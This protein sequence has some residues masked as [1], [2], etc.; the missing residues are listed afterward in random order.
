VGGSLS[1]PQL[2]IV[3]PWFNAP[4]HPAQSLINTA[5]AIGRHDA[6][7]YLVSCETQEDPR[8]AALRAAAGSVATFLLRGS[9]LRRGTWLALRQLLAKKTGGSLAGRVL[10]FD[11]HLALMALLWPFMRGRIRLD[12]LGL[13]YLAGPE[14]IAGNAFLRWRMQY[15][16]AFP[17]VRLFLRTEEL[18]RAWRDRFPECRRE[19]IAVLPSLEIPDSAPPPFLSAAPGEPLRFGVVGQ[20]RKG[21]GLEWLVP[22]FQRRPELGVLAVAGEFSDERAHRQLGFLQTYP[23]YRGGFLTEHALL[24]VARAQ[25]Y[26]LLLYDEWDNRMEAATLYLAARVGRPVVCYDG[27]W[28]ARMVRSYRCGFVL[29]ADRNGALARLMELPRRDDRGYAELLQGVA[30]LR[31]E[32]STPALRGEYLRILLGNVEHVS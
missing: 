4:G 22:E 23:N 30:R 25:D 12:W 28:L 7:S 18:A 15:L 31:E 19:S 9:S 13:L 24:E 3:Q 14:R 17:E 32:H 6:I 5:R 21:K 26:L 16:L 20:I 11:A 2:L 8:L 10:F 27:G 29:P 1:R